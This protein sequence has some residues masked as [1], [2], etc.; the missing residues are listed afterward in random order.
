MFQFSIFVEQ[1]D[2]KFFVAHNLDLWIVSQGNNYE[3]SIRNLK[4]ATE[5][6]LEGEDTHK[7]I[8]KL[9]NKHYSLTTMLI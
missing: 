7:I 4:E 6:Y 5:L 3:E 2:N 8:D 9:K 1:E